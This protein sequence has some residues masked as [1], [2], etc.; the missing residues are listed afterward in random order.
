MSAKNLQIFALICGRNEAIIVGQLPTHKFPLFILHHFSNRKIPPSKRTL[1]PSLSLSE[2]DQGKFLSAFDSIVGTHVF[3]PLGK[4][5]G[6]APSHSLFQLHP[7]LSFCGG[8]PFKLSQLGPIFQTCV[9]VRES[10][11][12]LTM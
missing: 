12:Q 11:K 9:T 3:P 1:F 5:A 7:P 10:S 2:N 6:P 4:P 8:F